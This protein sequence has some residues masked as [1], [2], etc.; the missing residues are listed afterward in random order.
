MTLTTLFLINAVPALLLV[1]GLVSLLAHGIYADRRQ[2][3]ERA[4]EVR[5]LPIE[6]RDR[7]AA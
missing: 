5:A 1:Y 6:Q 4:A 3:R 7:I 2:R